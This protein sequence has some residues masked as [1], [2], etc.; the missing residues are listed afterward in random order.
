MFIRTEWNF[1]IVPCL[2]VFFSYDTI[3][4]NIFSCVAVSA[5]SRYLLLS[6]SL[7]TSSEVIWSSTS[8]APEPNDVAQIT[9]IWSA[10]RETQNYK[11]FNTYNVFCEKFENLRCLQQWLYHENNHIL[12]LLAFCHF[13]QPSAHLP[14]YGT[15]WLTFLY[16]SPSVAQRWTISEE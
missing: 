13:F 5:I 3:A 15:T 8:N 4:F 16:L 7:L 9:S 2:G 6:F 10:H 11:A 12:Y 14:Y 1:H